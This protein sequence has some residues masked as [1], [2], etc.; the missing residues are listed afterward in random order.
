MN[1]LIL[2]YF[3]FNLHIIKIAIN[4][5]LLF[6]HFILFYIHNNYCNIYIY[7][8][9]LTFIFIL[10]VNEEIISK[11]RKRKPV[12]KD[13]FVTKITFNPD[14][15]ITDSSSDYSDSEDEWGA[16]NKPKIQYKTQV[17]KC[18]LSKFAEL[19]NHKK[20]SKKEV[21]FISENIDTGIEDK[22]SSRHEFLSSNKKNRHFPIEQNYIFK[23]DESTHCLLPSTI[24]ST[25][26]SVIE[27]TIKFVNDKNVVIDSNSGEIL[28]P[29]ENDCIIFIEIKD[30]TEEN[31]EIIIISDSEDDVFLVD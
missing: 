26:E 4:L 8:V 5:I 24:N 27:S 17:E 29:K 28:E 23:Y 3:S 7:N 12:V 15:Y 31:E 6:K 13:G 21:K 16:I 30:D 14:E 9:T 11:T 10:D 20:H 25:K 2:Y 18:K 22:C 1:K 19:E